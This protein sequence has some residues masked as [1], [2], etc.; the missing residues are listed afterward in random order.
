MVNGLKEN[1]HPVTPKGIWFNDQEKPYPK[2]ACNVRY[3]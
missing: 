1:G 2:E 3:Q